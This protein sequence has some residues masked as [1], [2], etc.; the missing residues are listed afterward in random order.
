MVLCAN[1]G[2]SCRWQFQRIK[3]CEFKEN[4]KVVWESWVFM[5]TKEWMAY[6]SFCWCWWQ[7]SRKESYLDCKL[8]NNWMRHLSKLEKKLSSWLKL[9]KAVAIILQLNQILLKQVTLKQYSTIKRPVNMEMLQKQCNHQ[10]GAKQALQWWSSENQI[11]GRVFGQRK[12]TINLN[13]IYGWTWY[14]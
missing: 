13:S 1:Q 5:E 10:I 8:D 12:S 9:R 7:W 3:K 2:K 4:K 11:K 6:T 14:Y